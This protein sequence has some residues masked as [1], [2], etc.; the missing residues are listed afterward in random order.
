MADMDPQFAADD[1]RTT[2]ATKTVLVEISQILG[3]YK[4]SSSSSAEPFRGYS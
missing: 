2:S 4:G 3:S 1:D